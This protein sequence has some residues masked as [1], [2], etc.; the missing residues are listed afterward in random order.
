ML[1]IFDT[2]TRSHDNYVDLDSDFKSIAC[3]H[4]VQ[5]TRETARLFKRQH[6]LN[7]HHDIWIGGSFRRVTFLHD[8]F[9]VLCSHIGTLEY[10]LMN[11]RITGKSLV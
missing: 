5:L 8:E 2:G 10:V 9:H 6:L 3:H 4:L 7:V 1:T 11:S